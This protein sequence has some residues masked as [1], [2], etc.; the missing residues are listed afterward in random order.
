MTGRLAGVRCIVTGAA[1]GIGAAT[2]R[3]F[4]TEGAR[5]LAVDRRPVSPSTGIEAVTCDV[6]DRHTAAQAVQAFGGADVLVTAAAISVGGALHETS[7]ATWR[8]VLEVNLMGTVVWMEA[9]LPFM[10]ASRSGAIITV[11]SQLAIA[12][13]RANASYVA[14]KGAVVALTRSLALDYAHEGIRVN[15]IV[16]GAIETDMLERSF[17]RA[18]A[19]DEAREGSRARHPMERFGRADEVA[20]AALYL[21]ADATFTTGALLPVDGGWLAG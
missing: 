1:G 9:V 3:Q 8:E 19:P 2:A 16:P 10:R 7:E 6:S 13:G 15:C 17:A 11:A 20:A 14:S 4:A 21:A 5:V 18:G 12:G